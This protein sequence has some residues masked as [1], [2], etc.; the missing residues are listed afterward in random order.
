MQHRMRRDLIARDRDGQANSLLIAR[1]P[2]GMALCADLCRIRSQDKSIGPTLD[3]RGLGG[4]G[5]RE[6]CLAGGEVDPSVR[7]FI[8]ISIRGGREVGS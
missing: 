5:E 7:S 2:G 8:H 1:I 6:N 3:G 4:R